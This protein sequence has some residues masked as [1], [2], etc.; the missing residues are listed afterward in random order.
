MFCIM[1]EKNY[2]ESE[3]DQATLPSG[4][5][6]TPYSRWPMHPS[7]AFSLHDNN[8]SSPPPTSRRSSTSTRNTASTRSPTVALTNM[9]AGEVDDAK[10]QKSKPIK[11]RKATASIDNVEME[12]LLS[13]ALQSR[14]QNGHPKGQIPIRSRHKKSQRSKDLALDITVANTLSNARSKANA[15]GS[16]NGGA[17]GAAK[18]RVIDLEIPR[19]VLHSSIGTPYI[20]SPSLLLL[21]RSN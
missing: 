5:D 11:R 15:N 8:S 19:K 2:I 6:S 18:S 12:V 14:S 13:P 17:M 4:T 1:W 21:T 3:F 16:I 9:H 10:P 20:P 7:N